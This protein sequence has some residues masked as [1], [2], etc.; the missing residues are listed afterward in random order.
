MVS[1]PTVEQARTQRDTPG[2]ES[3]EQATARK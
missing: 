1:V 2:E 3:N